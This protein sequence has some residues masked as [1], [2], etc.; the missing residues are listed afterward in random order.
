MNTNYTDLD[1][2]V[3][4]VRRV[5]VDILLRKMSDQQ[6]KENRRKTIIIST[7]VASVGALFFLV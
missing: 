4:P 7:V 2:N 3:E 1:P 6:K 5:D